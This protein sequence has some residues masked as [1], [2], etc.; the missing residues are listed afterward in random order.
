M[1]NIDTEYFRL[2]KVTIYKP[3]SDEFVIANASVGSCGLCG[4]MI[5]G[6]DGGPDMVCLSCGEALMRGELKTCVK[7]D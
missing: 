4:T 7:W 6:M 1:S 5:T 3:T 2:E